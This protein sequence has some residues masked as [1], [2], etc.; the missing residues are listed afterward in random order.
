MENGKNRRPWRAKRIS[1]EPSREP[2]HAF[3][4]GPKRTFFAADLYIEMD[5]A[6]GSRGGRDRFGG[7]ALSVDVGSGDPAQVCVPLAAFR[8]AFGWNCYCT[9][10]PAFWRAIRRGK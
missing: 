2:W 10:L 5:A 3:S 9:G 4:L 8:P 1:H 7:G 6:G